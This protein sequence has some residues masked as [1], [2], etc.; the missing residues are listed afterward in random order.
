I[1]WMTKKRAQLDKPDASRPEVKE[2]L[3]RYHANLG[4]FLVHRWVRQGA[5]RAKIAEVQSARDEIAEALKINP[6][7]HFGREKYQLQAIEWIMTA[8][9]V[10]RDESKDTWPQEVK[11]SMLGIDRFGNLPPE[12]AHDA[13]R[14]WSG[15]I[16]LGNAWESV[17]VFN[18]LAFALAHDTVDFT[19][20]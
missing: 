10:V 5:D 18:A 16:V 19:Q 1:D 7:A 15:L 17:D 3:Y 20:R 9:K 14:G 13:V 4:T 2:Q 11:A 12:Q 6:N 8:P